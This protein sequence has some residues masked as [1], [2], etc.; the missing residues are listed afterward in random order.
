M[1]KTYFLGEICD[2]DIGG[3]PPRNNK[4]FFGGTHVWVSI[5]ALNKGIITDTKEKLTDAGIKNSNVKLVPKGTVLLSFKLS[6]GKK[7][8]AG[9]DLYTNEAIAALKIKKGVSILPKY[10]YYWI[11]SVDWDSYSAGAVKGKC[12]NK[13]ILQTIPI[14]IPSLEQ[15]ER[16]I[17]LLDNVEQLKKLQRQANEEISKYLQA[18]F[19]EMFGSGK[20]NTTIGQIS[21]LVSS[22]STPLGGEKSY[23]PQGII[24]IRSQ[25]VLMNSLDLDGVAHISEATHKKMRRTWLKGGDVLL[26]ITGASLG[27]VAVYQGDD[28]NANVNQHVCIIRP[29]KNIVLPTYLCYY[30]SLP[31]AQKTV[32]SIQAGASRQALNFNQVKSLPI[33]L[34]STGLQEKFVSIAQTVEQVRRLQDQNRTETTRLFDSLLEK[35]FKEQVHSD[36]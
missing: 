2:I 7:A 13:R 20:P 34:P 12:L 25:N 30:L 9:T 14:K 29:K 26:N 33:Y 19:L 23:L 6:L 21:E 31:A 1:N 24:F 8:I 32:W 15:Q 27:R 3:T 5:S 36:S 35:H 10:L 18:V 28:F 22:G 4:T 17:S 16:A 11:D